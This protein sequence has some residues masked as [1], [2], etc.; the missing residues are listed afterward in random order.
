MKSHV[1]KIGMSW[2][3]YSCTETQKARRSSRKSK[4]KLPEKMI[5]RKMLAKELLIPWLN[6][7][8]KKLGPTQLQV[9]QSPHLFERFRRLLKGMHEL[10]RL[11]PLA[12]LSILDLKSVA[13][14]S[15]RRS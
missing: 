3:I 14:C 8:K 1:T 10:A 4:K 2:L 9:K 7:R 15:L 11:E 13:E 5:N 12:C 6:S